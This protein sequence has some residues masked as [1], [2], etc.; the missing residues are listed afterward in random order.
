MSQMLGGGPQRFAGAPAQRADR[1]VP[2][3]ENPRPFV[4]PATL[5]W[6]ADAERLGLALELFLEAPIAVRCTPCRLTPDDEGH[7]QLADP[8][9][10]EVHRDC[11][12]RSSVVGEW[13]DGHVDEWPDR[14]V[15][16][17][18]GPVGGGPT[19]RDLLRHRALAAAHSPNRGEPGAHAGCLTG[20]DRHAHDIVLPLTESRWVGGIGEHLFRR[21]C[22]LDVGRDR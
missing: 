21:T 6:R 9:C 17:V 19:F 22:D 13:F 2:R 5:P 1:L 14:S 8:M 7:K 3:A 15:Y 18:R 11:D 16:T 10:L 4:A 20:F 12:P